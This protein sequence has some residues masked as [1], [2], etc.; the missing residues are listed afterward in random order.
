M[1]PDFLKFYEAA[2]IPFGALTTWSVIRN[3]GFTNLKDKNF[4]VLGGSGKLAKVDVVKICLFKAHFEI[5][6]GGVG[7][8]AI[9]YLKSQGAKITTTCSVESFPLLT[10]LGADF[11]IDYKTDD[12]ERDVESHGP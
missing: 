9:Q 6:S 11:V 12:V 3:A 8:V 10:E 1:K 7:T 4:F 2:A 5:T